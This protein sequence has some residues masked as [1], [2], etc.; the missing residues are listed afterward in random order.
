MILKKI[1]LPFQIVLLNRRLCSGCTYPLDKCAR[2]TFRENK[3][4]IKCKCGRRFV[5]NLDTNT[6]K[7]AS[8]EEEQEYLNKT[9]I[10]K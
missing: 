8:F 5:L 3:A 9:L 7:R 1:F 10:N 2:E 4:M 6:Y